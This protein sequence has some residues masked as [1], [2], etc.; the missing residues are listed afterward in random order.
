MLMTMLVIPVN[1]FAIAPVGVT[2]GSVAATAGDTN[3]TVP[4]SLSNIPVEGLT[5]TSIRITYD[6]TK[7]TL[8]SI[9]AGAIIPTSTDLD[10]VLVNVTQV[11][12]QARITY[13]DTNGGTSTTRITSPGVLANLKFTVSKNAS[14]DSTL[15]VN[16]L[17]ELTQNDLSATTLAIGDMSPTSGTMTITA[18][19]ATANAPLALTTPVAG[20]DN[21]IAVGGA[22]K[23]G[24]VNV[25]EGTNPVI[26]TGTKT[27]AQ[28]VVI[29]GVNA[30]NVTAGGTGTAPTYSVDTSSV[31]AAGGDKALH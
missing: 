25:V 27:S 6:T 15:S 7:L 4:I 22:T 31:A 9:T 3:V 17:S 30:A 12:G 28:T 21:T 16:A 14:T 1:S 20:G 24:T 2:V 19:P 10:T 29:G 8:T 11:A 13:L 23:T 18:L 5:G 26:I